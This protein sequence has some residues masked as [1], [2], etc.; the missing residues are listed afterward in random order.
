MTTEAV[1]E[2]RQQ[3]VQ[4]RVAEK[5]TRTEGQVSAEIVTHAENGRHQLSIIG[6]NAFTRGKLR[7]LAKPV[8]GS[9]FAS[10]SADL[11]EVHLKNTTGTVLHFRGY[12]SAIK[13]EQTE[14]IGASNSFAVILTSVG[15]GMLGETIPEEKPVTEQ[16]VDRMQPGEAAVSKDLPDHKHLTEH[17]FTITLSGRTKKGVVRVRGKPRGSDRFVKISDA[18]EAISLR[19]K[20]GQVL[21]ETGLFDGFEVYQTESVDAGVNMSAFVSSSGVTLIPHHWV[22]PLRVR[23]IEA[24]DINAD[25]AVLENLEAAN[26]DINGGS[27]NGVDI[28]RNGAG[29]GRFTTLQVGKTAVVVETRAVNTGDGLSGGGALSGDLTLTVD[30]T[31]VRTSRTLT[32]GDGIQAIGDLS[33]DRTIAV[34]ST[35]VRTSGTQTIGGDK[36]FS[37]VA[38]FNDAIGVSKVPTNPVD[39]NDTRTSTITTVINLQAPNSYPSLRFQDQNGRVWKVDG[40]QGDV[41]ITGNSSGT[42]EF[43]VLWGGGFQF[44]N[45][46]NNMGL[47]MTPDGQLIAH[48]LP[49]SNPGGSN[50]IWNDGGTLKIT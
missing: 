23:D 16:L 10:I 36:T 24:Q 41:R 40:Y 9:Y 45:N 4:T 34:D 42:I 29:F 32:G 15:R 26:A 30:G 13:V 18:A 2:K 6:K 1:N 3:V 12:Y 50:R 22:N 5:V 48:Q 46:N 21:I 37:G 44:R 8:N 33:A 27:L 49:T 20:T 25:K 38:R 35:V 19:H 7:I 31:V 11:D 14:Q 43:V 39:I 28:G 17:H 47:E